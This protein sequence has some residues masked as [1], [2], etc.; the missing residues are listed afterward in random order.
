MTEYKNFGVNLSKGQAAK[1]LTALKKGEGTTIKLTK[2]DLRGE[3]KLPLTQ[4]QINKIQNAKNGVQLKLS[5]AQLKH[6]EKHGGFL[7]LAALIPTLG[8]VL[9]GVG[10]LAGGIASAVN[11][12]RNAN[13]Q[14]RHNKALEDIEQ[15]KSGSGVVANVAG[16]IPIIGGPIK[17]ALERIG[18]GYGGCVKCGK[19]IVGKGLYISPQ[20][21]V[22]GDGLF[23]APFLAK[24][25]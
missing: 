16:M 19:H 5:A 22:V 24:D 8:A 20:G 3:H 10:G 9:G 23:L 17:A 7:P 11:S 14:A 18:M 6:M 1:I 21:E 25:P 4:T 12:T 13:E 15:S 2:N